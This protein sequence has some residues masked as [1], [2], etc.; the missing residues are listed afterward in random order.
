[1]KY[2][3]LA[4]TIVLLITGCAQTI[5]VHEKAAGSKDAASSVS[6]LPFFIKTEIFNQETIWAKTWFS[7]TLKIDK[8]F[9]S[10]K[11]EEKRP[12]ITQSFT[13]NFAREQLSQLSDIKKDIFTLSE[14]NDSTAKGLVDAFLALSGLDD[15]DG[16]KEVLVS[17]TLKPEWVVDNT[18]TYYLNAPLPWFGSNNLNQKL[19]ADGT[20]SE[21]S[22]APD[23]KLA[24][25]ISSIIPFKE[26]LTGK[27][28]TP[29]NKVNNSEV[30]STL[31]LISAEN[32]EFSLLN[33]MANI[34]K[35]TFAYQVSINI[36]ETGYTYVFSK[37]CDKKESCVT[38]IALDL[39][40]GFFV[41]VPIAE[42]KAEDGNKKSDAKA[43]NFQGAISLP[44]EDTI[45]KAPEN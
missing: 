33:A 6:G 4:T 10:D 34:K 3:F 5:W 15:T 8:T 17:N 27:F 13:R 35:S 16:V 31:N 7:V 11:V 23:T 37:Q 30:S 42:I 41:R 9:V 32:P 36:Q 39:N 25:G 18:K 12:T 2:V 44:K 1:M 40:R 43:I 45:P 20:L 21:V 26:Y 29:L 19:N 14:G 38:P 24:E 22:S 28:V